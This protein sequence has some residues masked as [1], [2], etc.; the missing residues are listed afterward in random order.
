MVQH[1]RGNYLRCPTTDT[2]ISYRALSP[3]EGAA[4]YFERVGRLLFLLK[5]QRKLCYSHFMDRDC[6]LFERLPEGDD[7]WRASVSG[8]ENAQ[9]KLQELGKSSA[10]QFYAIYMPTRE[11]VARVNTPTRRE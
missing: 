6:E 3:D 7:V 10:N 4:C 2:T 11:I 1:R 8:F 9:L 5:E